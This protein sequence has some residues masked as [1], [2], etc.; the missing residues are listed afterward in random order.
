M[1]QARAKRDEARKLI[2][3]GIDPSSKRKAEKA[4]LD[5]RRCADQDFWSRGV[6]C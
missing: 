3:E 2:A 6:E 4:A 5:S 1:K